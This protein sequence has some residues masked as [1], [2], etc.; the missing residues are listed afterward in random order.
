[1]S[2]RSRAMGLA[3]IMLASLVLIPS[4]PLAGAT[5]SSVQTCSDGSVW[6]SEIMPL[7]RRR[8][9]GRTPDLELGHVQSRWM[10]DLERC[11]R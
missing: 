2:G 8:R 1:M 4:A 5:G 9:L 10:G 11:G 3:I 6:I 7:G